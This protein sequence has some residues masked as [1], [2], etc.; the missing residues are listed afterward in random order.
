MTNNMQAIQNWQDFE[1]QTGALEGKIALVTGAADGIGRAL[2]FALAQHGVTV[3][4]LDK[5]RFCINRIRIAMR[6]EMT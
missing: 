5:L 3:I 1:P 6:F 4:M 2:T